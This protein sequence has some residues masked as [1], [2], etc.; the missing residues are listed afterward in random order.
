MIDLLDF[1]SA[2][3]GER[4][5][6]FLHTLRGLYE[7]SFYRASH[8]VEAIGSIAKDGAAFAENFVEAEVR[9]LDETLDQAKAQGIARIRQTIEGS[10]GAPLP[11]GEDY[12]EE[13]LVWFRRELAVQ[14]FRDVN[15]LAFARRSHALQ[16]ASAGRM[17]T[18]AVNKVG[19]L[20]TDRSGRKYPAQKFYRNL[21]RQTLLVFAVESAAADAASFGYEEVYIDHADK[22]KAY[23]GVP[24]TLTGNADMLSLH[25]VRDEVFHP[26]ATAFLTVQQ[27]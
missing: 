9:R 25:D 16:N 4:Y 14:A 6:A 2:R 24:I 26:N 20:F 12:S 19:F 18:F 8:D 1:E 21:Y 27:S 23:M 10:Q 11:D 15:T 3:A 7:R 22:N 13:L 17:R 5:V